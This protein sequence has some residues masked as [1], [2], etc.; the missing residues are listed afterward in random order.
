[1]KKK[2]ID[3]EEKKFDEFIQ[4]FREEDLNN[5]KKD[6]ITFKGPKSKSMI[7]SIFNDY[8]KEV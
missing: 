1:L 6:L 4:I 7:L 2:Q 5:I 8:F 3:F